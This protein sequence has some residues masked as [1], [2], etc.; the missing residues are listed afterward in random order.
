MPEVGVG[1]ILAWHEA[2]TEVLL[3]SAQLVKSYAP[4]A[5]QTSPAPVETN[6][7][8]L[9]NTLRCHATW[10]S[11]LIRLAMVA[12]SCTPNP[13][14]RVGRIPAWHEAM[15]EL[16]LEF[17]QLLK[18]YVP[19]GCHISLACPPVETNNTECSTAL[20]CHRTSLSF[21]ILPVVAALSPNPQPELGVDRVPTRDSAV[22]ELYLELTQLSEEVTP[23]S[24]TNSLISSRFSR[25]KSHCIETWLFLVLALLS[26]S[27]VD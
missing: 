2:V 7:L 4:Y 14:L 1:R 25:F 13:K 8:E 6:T 15:T 17:T 18:S 27:V 20:C 21:L 12:L 26:I 5:G 19:Y 16:H 9:S 3:E 11:F 10:L 23:M 24:V 22:A